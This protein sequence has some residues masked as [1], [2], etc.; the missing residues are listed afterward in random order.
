MQSELVGCTVD[1]VSR[2]E[3]E[4]LFIILVNYFLRNEKPIGNPFVVATP[5]ERKDGI[6]VMVRMRTQVF[7]NP[8]GLVT[9]TLLLPPFPFPHTSSCCSLCGLS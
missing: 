5:W 6:R 9:P 8:S 3:P 4:M 7:Y 2:P 1:K